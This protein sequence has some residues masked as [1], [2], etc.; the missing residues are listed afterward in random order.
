MYI[1]VQIMITYNNQK[2]NWNRLCYNYPYALV[3][4]SI[5]RPVSVGDSE[6]RQIIAIAIMIIGSVILFM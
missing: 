6:Y 5:G 1:I 3:F 4:Y 2:R